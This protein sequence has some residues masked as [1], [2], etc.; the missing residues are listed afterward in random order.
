MKLKLALQRPG[1]VPVDIVVTADATATVADVARSIVDADPTLENRPDAH[2]PLTLK[3]SPPESTDL[4]ALN[5]DTPIGEA[6][7][8]SG[9]NAV[10]VPDEQQPSG[11]AHA[12]QTGDRGAVAAYLRIVA[13]PGAGRQFGLPLGSSSIGR[14]TGN[15]V[16]IDDPLVSKRHARVDVTGDSI[17]VIDLNSANGILV[18]G[19]QVSRVRLESGQSVILGDTE[20]AFVLAGGSIATTREQI[21]ER[22]GVLRFNRSPR[23]EAR[24]PGREFA[25]PDVPTETEPQVFPWIMVVAPVLMGGLMF[26]LTKNPLSLAFVAMAPMMMMGNYIAQASGVK[27]KLRVSTEKFELQIEDLESEFAHEQPVERAARLRESPSVAEVYAEALR[28]GPML[29]TRRPEHWNFLDLR[30]GL[31]SMPSRNVIK[32]STET[33]GLPEFTRMLDKL[34]SR[35]ERIE[36]VPLVE[37]VHLAGALGVCGPATNVA[38]TVRALAVQYV[39][40]HSPAEVAVAAILGARSTAEFEWLKWLPH[41]SSPQSPLQGVQLANSASTATSVLNALEELIE[42]RTAKTRPNRGAHNEGSAASQRGAKVGSMPTGNADETQAAAL[43]I[44]I[45]NDAPV[46]RARLVN[47]IERAADA[48]IYPIWMSPNVEALPAAC[49]TFVDVGA[50]DGLEDATVGF[51][52]L[53]M[54]VEHVRV[55]GVSVE[56]AQILS[57][58]LAPVID[59]SAVVADASDLPRSVSMLALMGT[60]LAAEPQAAIERWMQNN[61]IHDRSG[62]PPVARKRAGTLRAIIGQSSPDAMHLDLRTQGPHALVG[63]TTGAGKSEFLQAWVLGMAAEYS[64]D[65]VTFL[66]VDYKGG[67][68]FADCVNLPHCVGLVTDLSP[69]LVRRA[70]TSLRAEL[71]YREHLLNRKKA[72]DLIELE[73]RGD[74][75]CPPALILVIDEFAALAGEVPEFVD[76]VV[77]IGQRG[78]SLGIHLI[79]ATQR[80]AGVIKDNLRANTNLRVALRMADENDSIDV[81]GDKIAG[82]FDPSIPGRGIAKTGPGRLTQ[83]Q[84]G[85]AGGWTTDEPDAAIVTVSELRFGAEVQWEPEVIGDP[86][87]QDADLGPNDQ[88]RLVRNL[89]SATDTMRIP[90]PRRPWLDELSSTVDLLGLEQGDDTELVMGMVDRPERQQQDRACFY[91]DK[92]GHMAIFGTSGSGKSVLLRSL[93]IA[94]GLATNGTVHVY[95]LDFGT[96]TLRMLEALPH[97]GSIVSGDDHE[98]VTRLLRTLRDILDDRS[99]RYSEVNASNIVEYRQLAGRPDEPRIL[100]LLDSFPTFKDE[101]DAGIGRTLYYNMLVGMLGEG[102]PL[103]LHIVFTAD[104]ANSVPTP[105]AS[106]IQRRVILRLA[107]ENSYFM[108]DVAKDILDS[109]SPPGRAIIDGYE[110]Q[111]GVIDGTS[112][113][114]EQSKGIDRLAASLAYSGRVPAPP[115]GQLPRELRLA[116]LPSAVGDQPAIGI[117]DTDLRP[118]GFEP[119]GSFLVA[120]PPASGKSTALVSLAQSVQRFDPAAKLFF[121]GSRRS[122]IKDSINWIESALNPEAVAE[123][124]T[125]LL[126]LVTDEEVTNKIVVVID[127]AADFQSGPADSALTELIKAVNR[128][129][130]LILTDGDVSALSAS[131]GMLGE[132]KAT[133]RGIVLMPDTFDG[134]SIFK[135]SFPRISRNESPPGRGFYVNGAQVVK[136]QVPLAD[137]ASSVPTAVPVPVPAQ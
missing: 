5:A 63:G 90:A 38:D 110:G 108:F 137:A 39:G 78:R 135:V 115:V 119:F 46:D 104:R 81:V 37:N 59:A 75:D 69:H 95:G 53:G 111:I 86:N 70:L 71:H 16:V 68:A 28:L 15:D 26:A 98:R 17:E 27:R 57:K 84:S 121:F 73:K 91:P 96:G 117:A 43:V 107:D 14:V 9:F 12:A 130:H 4:V 55:E 114:A 65:R 33:R 47:V 61:S 8:G 44:L 131:W 87:V 64:S 88:V 62:A 124:A 1:A 118:A 41:T 99:R 82:G 79:M 13:G 101:Y 76:G 58:R 22:G 60:D 11:G 72:K 125:E 51:V 85:Y 45:D 74:P 36:D 123:L 127:N 49:R 35:V 112:N 116:E 132:L 3:V 10:V 42:T 113:V 31:G 105:V 97:V 54:T 103:G 94:A 56:Y 102:R 24:Y 2:L 50:G 66:F 25:S 93:G 83:F 30:L 109:N 122:P 40:L 18:D 20:V 23:V 100:L 6:A 48:R 21:L 77:D 133:R 19:G 92:D 7:F 136:V 120:G 32:S 106:N 126:A 67:S 34:R 29:W 89:I 134:D 128:S 80:P 129:D 52:R